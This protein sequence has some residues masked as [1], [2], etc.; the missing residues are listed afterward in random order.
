M[1]DVAA[2][3]KV[4]DD[5]K[6]EVEAAVADFVAKHPT[7]VALQSVEQ[8]LATLEA[9]QQPLPLL[10]RADLELLRVGPKLPPTTIVGI[11]LD[12]IDG[13]GEPLTTA[14][15]YPHVTRVKK[16][17]D[18]KKGKINVV[19]AMSKDRKRIRSLV[20]KGQYAWWPADT[21]LPDEHKKPRSA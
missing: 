17:P 1:A 7:N 19:S 3:R 18:A 21:A 8:A 13:A 2:L 4:R 15:I 11:A 20:W 12:A 6:A 16:F 9:E 10:T 5:L 14:E